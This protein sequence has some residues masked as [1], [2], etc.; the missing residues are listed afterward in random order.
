MS[1]IWF[2]VGHG[3]G[4][5]GAVAKH[6]T[7]VYKEH[8]ECKAILERAKRIFASQNIDVGYVPIGLSLLSRIAWVNHNIRNDHLLIELH[9]NGDIKGATGAEIFF[10]DGQSMDQQR[11]EKL[12][13]AYVRS[14]GQK[15]RGTKPDSTTRHGRLGILRDVRC[16]ANLIELG[17]M[18]APE[19]ELMQSKASL[20]LANIALSF[21]NKPFLLD[22]GSKP[23]EQKVST[24]AEGSVEKAKKAKI[25]EDWTT[26]QDEAKP[27]WMAHVLHKLGGLSDA[28]DVLTKERVAVALDRLG[29][30]D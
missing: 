13:G 7:K 10:R 26:P 21:Y 24:W 29:L 19:I 6:G 3:A 23:M 30:L 16:K 8:D 11:G 28:T 4:D 25:I 1:K 9:M 5:P 18:N 12:L 20:G 27:F 22:Y 15:S 17:F 2:S 14:T